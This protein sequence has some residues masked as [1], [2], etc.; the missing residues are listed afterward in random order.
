MGMGGGPMSP[1]P[2]PGGVPINISPSDY[3]A[4]EQELIAI[5]AAWSAHDLNRLSGLLTPEMLSYFGEQ[6]AQQT[7]R[8]VRNQVTDVRLLQGDLAQAW[9][10]NTPRWPCGFP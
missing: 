4:F 5:Q 8:G 7:S 2:R 10:V 9:A 3:Q 1:R 6:L